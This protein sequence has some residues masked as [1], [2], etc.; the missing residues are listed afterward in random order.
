MAKVTGATA[1]TQLR[2]PEDGLSRSMLNRAG[3]DNARYENAAYRINQRQKD[4]QARDDAFIAEFAASN[5]ALKP[6]D[7]KVKSINEYVARAI[8]K[9]K[10]KLPELYK[11]YSDPKSTMQQKIDAK[12]GI[13]EI[14]KLP[15]YLKEMTTGITKY[16][17]TQEEGLAD[18]T[19]LPTESY[20]NLNQLF[21]FTD[22]GAGS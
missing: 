10:E 8:E 12:M 4:K 5:S 20:A 16:V 1:Y 22:D 7:T 21:D 3:Q 11:V 9:G 19:L 17:T 13:N 14:E 18:G 2:P 15:D 6:F